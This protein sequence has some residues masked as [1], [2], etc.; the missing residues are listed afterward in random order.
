MPRIL[1]ILIALAGAGQLS[2]QDGLPPRF[3]VLAK[4]EHFKLLRVMGTP[5]L[6]AIYHQA[7]AFSA[8]GKRAIYCEDLS[9]GGAEREKDKEKPRPRLRTRLHLWDIPARG[10]PREI[11][12]D[13]KNVTALALSADGATALL[14]GQTFVGKDKEPTTYLALWDLDG[15]KERRVLLT[16][17]D[18]IHTVAL[19]PD[20]KTALSATIDKL[21]R[22]DLSQG[23]ALADYMEKD[24]GPTSALAFLP[25]G[26][27]FLTGSIKGEIR[28][29]DVDKTTPARSYK[30]K[31]KLENLR[32]LAVSRD[33]KRFALGD[34]QSSVSLWETD[35][36]KELNSLKVEKRTSEE[37]LSAI[38]LADDAR[39]VL[40]VWARAVPDA[41]DFQCARLF[42]WDGE[43][44]K[45][46]WS[47]VV[48]YRGA[49]PMLVQGDKLTVGGGP[50]L[51]ETWSIKDGKQIA[52]VGAHKGPV[53]SLAALANGD[54]LSAGHEG[55]L[56]TWRDGKLS[57]RSL[58]H[59]GA[60]TALA[61]AKDRTQYV[62]AGADLLI[63]PWP[64]QTFKKP[65]L[66][67][68]HTAPITSLVFNGAASWIASGS[69]DRSIKTWDVQGR[70]EIATFTGHAE[71]VNAVAI[72]PD[73][74]WIAS[75]SDDATI[76]LWPV[77]DGKLDADRDGIT[78]EGHKKPVMCIA[79]TVDGKT[80]LSG[81][82]DGTV[83]IWDWAKEKTTRTIPA[84]KNWITALTFVDDNT[85]LTT[86]DDLT[87][88]LWDYPTGKEIGRLDLGAVGDC[89]RCLARA[90][91]R[92]WIGSSS[93]LIYEF[94]LALPK[95]K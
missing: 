31:R 18:Q 51:F 6:P 78:L 58:I 16:K 5:E 80:L 95:S 54:L 59:T 66:P 2:A 8:D 72:S 34:F 11:E 39:T 62:T 65:A 60:I 56:M 26:K 24:L 69:G 82:Q 70:K 27:Q 35:T 10:W 15:G 52:S 64:M 41:D 28:L 14:A 74:R 45:K 38:A 36:G 43:T 88:C 22:W 50:N 49:V 92:L 29:W 30:S 84:H 89:P 87:V 40:S 33:G 76:R 55:V 23:K 73:G 47:H 13:G 46:Q 3:G 75:G 44:G 91:D 90:G 85:L 94:Q 77:K 21:K 86:S 12:I 32:H 83:K 9:T 42:A 4:N 19:A 20:E 53:T 61:V 1:A 68:T 7:S 81:S 93:W 17:E 25:G 67:K 71:G 57:E 63:H 79:F 37:F 48:P